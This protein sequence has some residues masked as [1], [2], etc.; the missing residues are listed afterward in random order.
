MIKI[1]LADDHAM[2]REGL[3]QIL[4]RHSD[5]KI[6]GEACSGREAL[7]AILD[8]D[9]DVVI[10]DISMPG[11]SG[12][13]VLQ[14]IKKLRP[15]L[16]VLILSMHPEE[17]YA[18]RVLKSGASGYLTKESAADELIS[19]IRKI[20]A[21]GKYISPLLAERLADSLDP[22]SEIPS[23]QLL[24]DREFEVLR[25][26]AGGKSIKGIADQL[27]LSEKT[28]TTYR[29]RILEK[30]DLNNNAELTKY[31]LENKLLE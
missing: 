7:S 22:S 17:Q 1:F 15:K 8:C 16:G 6:V 27:S 23:H 25:Q 18:L 9:C 5:F 12:A 20:A 24:S 29:A 2:F 19:A 11:R 4:S 28:I 30:L 10:L 31:A 26:L 13:E 3:I 14:E 21:G